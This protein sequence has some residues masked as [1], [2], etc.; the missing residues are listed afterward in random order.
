MLFL[1][2]ILCNA[3]SKFTKSTLF[4]HV[5]KDLPI[6]PTTITP[7]KSLEVTLLQ[8]DHQLT[9]TIGT[10]KMKVLLPIHFIFTRKITA[11]QIIT[12]T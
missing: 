12:T 11:M 1:S 3:T 5:K 9:P 8:M 2:M 10:I 7:T 4:K 6:V